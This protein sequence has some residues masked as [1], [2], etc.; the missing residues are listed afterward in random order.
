MTGFLDRAIL[1]RESTNIEVCFMYSQGRCVVARVKYQSSTL[2]FFWKY[3]GRFY[4]ST[5]D[6]IG[7]TVGVGNTPEQTE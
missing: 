2:H 3:V 1:Q 5:V 4:L 7:T 6:A